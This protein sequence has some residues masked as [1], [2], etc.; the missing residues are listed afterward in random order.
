MSVLAR[1]RIRGGTARITRP[2][3]VRQA[4]GSRARVGRVDGTA[5]E[6]TVLQAAARLRLQ[7]L[8]AERREH[9]FGASAR[10]TDTMRTPL[11]WALA[12]DDQIEFLD[13][14]MAGR[15][16]RVEKVIEYRSRPRTAHAECAVI[17]LPAGAL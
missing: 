9:V 4:D 14:A 3:S 6:P 15:R 12:M 11:S 13:G 8:A 5:P 7:S 1:H 16:F 2:Q 10:A 17:E